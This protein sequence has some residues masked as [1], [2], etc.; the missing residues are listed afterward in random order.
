MTT[1]REQYSIP[2]AVS[3]YVDLGGRRMHYVEA[4]RGEP[5]VLLHG[6]PTSSFLWRGVI[7]YIAAQARCIA[8]DLMGMGGSDPPASG[9]RF[10]HHY[11][12][13]RAFLDALGIG[14][15]TFVGH[16]WG[17]SLAFRHLVERPDDVRGLAFM[18]VMLEALTWAEMP[19]SF[20]AGFRM[21]RTPGLGWLLLSV[22]NVFV[23]LVLPMATATRLDQAAMQRYRAPFRTIRSRQAVRQWPL[24][25]P[26]DGK[27]ADNAALFRGY[28]E[29]LKASP[30]PKLLCYT[31][32][33][34]VVGS[35]RREWAVS[36]LPHLE[37]A[38]CGE[39]I[40]F[41]PEEHPDAIGRA[42]ADWLYRKIPATD[43]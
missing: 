41:M 7:P 29:A 39:G 21:M 34:A 1:A 2:N 38:Y 19:L 9:Y 40:H 36:E 3:R 24:E 11:D 33:G 23:N 20:R 28:T 6:N 17:G 15:A 5:V 18:E 10:E 14:P 30:V 8:P 12:Y 16:D 27:P 31:Q 42:L 26:L 43:A 35:R 37:T 4:G 32:P 13:L 25:V 22:G